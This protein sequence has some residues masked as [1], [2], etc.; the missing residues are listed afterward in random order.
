ME[1]F[2]CIIVEDEP[3]AAEVLS[4]YIKQTPFLELVAVCP[5]AIY[6]LEFLQKQAIDL[7]FLDIHLPKLRGY[8]FI[9]TL[10]KSP[11]II[12]TT[13]YREYALEGYDLNVVDYLLKP[14][15]FNRFLTAIN[16]VRKLAD[17]EP[18]QLHRP[19]PE[20]P[21][22]PYLLVNVNKK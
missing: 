15:S 20:L 21:E 4:D 8:D 7:V 19:S 16:K 13:A 11:Q 12:I 6:A 22:T 3:L 18:V 5:D 1:K 2:N 9:R 17:Q 10:K 14:I